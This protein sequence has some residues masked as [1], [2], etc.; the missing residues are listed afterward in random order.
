M[1]DTPDPARARFFMLSAIR[2]GGV[3]FAFLGIAILVKRW[4]E[5]AELVG[6]TLIAVG[7]FEV[8]AL[9][10]ILARQWRTPR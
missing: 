9:P 10:L 3:V 1:T 2:L 7:A 5:P 8:M 4:V 6:W